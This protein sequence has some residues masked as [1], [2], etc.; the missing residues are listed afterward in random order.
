MAVVGKA[1]SIAL[2]LQDLMKDALSPQKEHQTQHGHPF[3]RKYNYDYTK[4]DKSCRI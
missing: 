3:Y 2:I 1:I 4:R